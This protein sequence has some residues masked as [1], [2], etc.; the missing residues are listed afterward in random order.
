MQ[1]ITNS[2]SYSFSIKVYI[3]GGQAAVPIA[4]EL[5]LTILPA[6]H[7]YNNIHHLSF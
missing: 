1:Y 6:T 7:I 3:L 5:L 2:P 4:Q